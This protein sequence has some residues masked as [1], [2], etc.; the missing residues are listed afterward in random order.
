MV[1]GVFGATKGWALGYEASLSWWKL[2]LTTEGEY[3]FD[4]GDSDDNFYYSWSELTLAP[5]DWLFF[6]LAAQRTKIYA[7]DTEF[8]PGV[9]VGGTLGMVDLSAYVFDPGDRNPTY[10]FAVTLSF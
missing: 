8:T 5:N 6:G 4:T 1:G 2:E 9:V 7:T 3:L 10:V